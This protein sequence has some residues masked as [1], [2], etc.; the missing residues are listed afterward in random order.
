MTRD[1][2]PPGRSNQR[3]GYKMEADEGTMIMK[4]ENKPPL[5]LQSVN[6]EAAGECM[7]VP[8]FEDGRDID[9]ASSYKIIDNVG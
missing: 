1:L 8:T 5:S 2:I 9:L 3:P 6:Q 7:I 4:D